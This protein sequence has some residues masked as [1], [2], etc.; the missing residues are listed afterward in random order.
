MKLKTKKTTTAKPSSP[1]FR[2]DYVG[3][4]EITAFSKKALS[5]L[6]R[7]AITE[8]WQWRGPSLALEPSYAE[9]IVHAMVAAGFV[10][11]T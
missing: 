6:R 1:D 5:W 7:N 11:D 8:P 9:P 2:V 10:Q 3:I 4:A